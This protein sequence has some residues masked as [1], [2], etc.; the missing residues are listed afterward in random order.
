MTKMKFILNSTLVLGMLLVAS[1]I[2]QAQVARTWVS[3]LGSDANPCSLTAP[4][5][6][7]AGAY[8]KTLTGGQINLLDANSVGS[9]TISKSI[10]VD[11]SQSFAGLLA[12]GGFNSI[13][14]NTAATDVVV[15]RGLS[16]D[17]NLK[18][19]L[20]GVKFIQGGELHVENCTIQNFSGKGI[21]FEP[22]LVN[23]R[24]FVKDCILR[25][26]TGAGISIQPGANPASAYVVIDHTRMDSNQNGLTAFDKTQ[27]TVSDS[28]ASGNTANGFL[29][30]ASAVG[31][32]E[33]NLE[34]C[35]ATLNGTN[36]IRA[37]GGG[38]NFATIRATNVAVMNNATGL[39]TGANG[40]LFSFA[41]NRIAGNS[42]G[43][44]SFT[45]TGMEQ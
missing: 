20:S 14:V 2:A 24:L 11:A 28:T 23:S 31:S 21:T 32:T 41:N 38:G 3:G 26:N 7:L 10:T 6:T 1:S 29:A 34:R 8:N 19:G 18:T 39:S 27:V 13:V 43:D 22:T 4:C 35:V 36:G 5:K 33:V 9:L 15:L 40:V 42:A 30:T 37:I 44:G 25:N 16:I 45:N 12:V 17:G